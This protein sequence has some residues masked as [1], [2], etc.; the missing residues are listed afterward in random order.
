DPS[1]AA[2]D[3]E[4]QLAAFRKVRDG[5]AARVRALARRLN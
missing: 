1:K 5:I 3:E 2:G 4:E